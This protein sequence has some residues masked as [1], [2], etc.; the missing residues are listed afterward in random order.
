MFPIEGAL[1]PILITKK[2]SAISIE[3]GCISLHVDAGM[4]QLS[5]A[6]RA[7]N[8]S[9]IAVSVPYFCAGCPHNS[10]KKAP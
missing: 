10:S 3:V 2:L 7:N 6:R 8:G 5:E 4:A 9:D 1:D